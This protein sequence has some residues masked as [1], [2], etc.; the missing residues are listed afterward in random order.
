MKKIFVV[1]II[2]LIA[3][4]ACKKRGICYC[5]FYSGDKQEY[6]LSDIGNRDA[7]KDSCNVIDGNAANFGG[8]CKLK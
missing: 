8:S 6:D 2:A 1:L 4:A 7:Q 3:L 5:K